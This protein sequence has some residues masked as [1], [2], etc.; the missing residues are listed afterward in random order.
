MSL[1][2][3]IICIRY[4]IRSFLLTC[5]LVSIYGVF[6]FIFAFVFCCLFLVGYSF[7]FFTFRFI[8][9]HSPFPCFLVF[10]LTYRLLFSVSQHFNLFLRFAFF[11]P[12]FLYF[13]FFVFSIILLTHI[14]IFGWTGWSFFFYAYLFCPIV[15]GFLFHYRSV[16]PF[17]HFVFC[18]SPLTFLASYAYCL[19]PILIFVF[20]PHFLLFPLCFLFFLLDFCHIF[21]HIFLAA[22][23]CF[24]QNTF[25]YLVRCFLSCFFR[26]LLFFICFLLLSWFTHLSFYCFLFSVFLFCASRLFLVFWV[27][28]R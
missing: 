4:V 25:C 17:S 14:S 1:S 28:L 9:W 7:S 10:F 27:V 18:F 19:F 11:I 2:Y 24:C 3:S 12:L 26:C 23:P 13:P 16:S 6:S 8:V 22:F 5:F 21:L 20:S 15:F